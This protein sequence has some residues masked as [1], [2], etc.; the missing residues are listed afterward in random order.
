MCHDSQFSVWE[1]DECHSWIYQEGG[2]PN[3]S[4]YLV[5]YMSDLIIYKFLN[6]SE[7]TGLLGLTRVGSRRAIQISAGFMLFFSVLGML[8]HRDKMIHK[9]SCF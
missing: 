4:I 1:P 7:N 5:A 6:Y 8:L 2:H 9:L 3:L